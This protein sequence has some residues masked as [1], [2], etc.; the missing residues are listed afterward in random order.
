MNQKSICGFFIKRS[1]FYAGIAVAVYFVVCTVLANLLATDNGQGFS[2]GMGVLLVIIASSNKDEGINRFGAFY[3]SRKLMMRVQIVSDVVLA[4]VVGLCFMAASCIYH[5]SP[6][7]MSLLSYVESNIY[8]ETGIIYFLM[9]LVL[10]A[11]LILDNVRR[12]P[13]FRGMFNAEKSTHPILGFIAYIAIVIVVSIGYSFI[14][15]D[16]AFQGRVIAYGVAIV[17][18]VTIYC[19]ASRISTKKEF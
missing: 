13:W 2:S 16:L 10:E 7:S 11:T 5:I 17:A 6:Q 15:D 19:I 14:H 18:I 4:A 8:L 9:I 12:D 1:L 3:S